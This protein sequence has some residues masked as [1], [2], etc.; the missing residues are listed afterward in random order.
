MKINQGERIINTRIFFL[1]ALALLLASITL[2]VY[3]MS[4]SQFLMAGFWLLDGMVIKSHPVDDAPAS[5]IKRLAR[6]AGFFLVALYRNFIYKWSLFF[7]NKA[8]LVFSSIYLMHLLGVIYS[9][10]MAYA[11]TDLR[12]KV[13][14]LLLPLFLCTIAPLNY[15]ELKILL[16]I[17]CGGI[18]ANT[19]ISTWIFFTTDLTDP[20]E[21]S[22]YISHIRLSL[23]VC[24]AVFVLLYMIA[25]DKPSHLWEKISLIFLTVWFIAFLILLKSVSGIIAF[26]SVVFMIG[27]FFTTQL[28]SLATKLILFLSIV[29]GLFSVLIFIHSTVKSYAT[30]EPV[31]FDTLATHTASGNPYLH[32]TLTLGIENG[33]YVGLYLSWDEL[34][35]AW[36][37]R[38]TFDFMGKDIQKQEIRFTLVRYLTSKKL[39]KDALGVAAL[40]PQDIKN[41]ELGVAN[42]EYL[43]PFNLKVKIWDAASGFINLKSTGDPNA[44]TFL[45]RVEY[46]KTSWWIIKRHPLLGV[47]TGD[48]N[49]AFRQAYEKTNTPLLE[50]FRWRSHNQFMSICVG[51]GFIGLLWFI[52][53]LFYP[54]WRHKGYKNYFFAAFFIIAITSF[55]S[56]DT[57]ETQQGVTFVALFYSL[58]LMNPSKNITPIKEK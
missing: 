25:K 29:V 33:R 6:S 48:M 2:S 54:A 31:L 35:Q 32:D 50:R 38:S 19:F 10:D 23:N 51:F 24:L 37:Q 22:I 1:G 12:I 57:I 34:Q 17:Y 39:R 40:S 58:F 5:K 28:R 3:M 13:P 16:L 14:L 43:K 4:V 27:L 20:R 7:R 42:I 47:G 44:N 45:Q 52:F 49:I 9:T 36:N 46:W 21:M 30:P 18:L 53:A 41:I 55:F 8:A 15:K 56:E 26:L 11:L